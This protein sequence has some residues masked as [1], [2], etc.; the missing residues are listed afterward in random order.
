MPSDTVCKFH[1]DVCQYV[2]SL[3]K[4]FRSVHELFLFGGAIFFFSLFFFCSVSQS[5]E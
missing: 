2:K 4:T 5:D 3:G 1:Q